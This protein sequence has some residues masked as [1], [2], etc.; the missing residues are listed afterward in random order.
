[1]EVKREFTTW[2]ELLGHVNKN[3][4]ERQRILR[5]VGVRAITVRRW[6]SGESQPRE[7]NIRRLARALPSE[8][9]VLFL[10]LV[11]KSFPHFVRGK[12]EHSPPVISEISSELYAQAFEKY[13]KT[14]SALASQHLQ[15]F[16]LKRAIE[17]LDPEGKGMC[18]SFVC[19]MPLSPGQKI[20]SLRQ[21]SGIGTPP[22]E[23]DIE[24]KTIFLGSESLAGTAVATAQLT[25]IDSR[26]SA[27]RLSAHWTEF[28]NSAAAMPILR[29]GR[30]AGVLLVSS[31]CPYYFTSAHK[32]L[33]ELYA[34][35]AVLIFDPDEFYNPADIQLHAMPDYEIQKPY[36]A[37]VEQRTVRKQ[38]ESMARGTHISIQKARQLVW[39]EIE[40]ELLQRSSISGSST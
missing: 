23:R 6:I 18:I 20:R 29:Q 8:I 38:A 15:D 10:Q 9:G 26:D 5:E 14:P 11:E 32:A 7:E 2:Q 35:L 25:W 27:P 13:A 33:L 1:M 31:A 39:Q 40:L 34:Q 19:C 12:V 3:P 4:Q 22:W 24:R 21:I 30:I 17:H 16:L 37:H 36:F 28:E